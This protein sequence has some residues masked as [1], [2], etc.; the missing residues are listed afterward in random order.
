MT[1]VDENKKNFPIMVCFSR[2]NL[3]DEDY[4][5]CLQENTLLNFPEYSS[6]RMA[7]T[8]FYCSFMVY[9]QI[10]KENNKEVLKAWFSQDALYGEL[11]EVKKGNQLSGNE[12]LN[13][14]QYFDKLFNIKK[15]FTKRSLPLAWI[16]I[17][18][19]G[20]CYHVT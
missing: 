19:I 10:S 1:W 11:Y 16:T 9:E 3:F 18:K 2:N 20:L 6:Y 8:Q 14:Y 15:T 17:R 12:I 13:I 7:T 4:S 5:W